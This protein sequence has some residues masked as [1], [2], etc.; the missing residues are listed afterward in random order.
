[1]VSNILDEGT[2][3]DFNPALMSVSK[4]PKTDPMV[5][6]G[7]SLQ[8]NGSSE[9]KVKKRNAS[10]SSY[11]KLPLLALD[12]LPQRLPWVTDYIRLRY[13]RSSTP[14]LPLSPGAPTTD[15][16]HA[17]NQ[18]CFHKCLELDRTN[19]NKWA[20]LLDDSMQLTSHRPSPTEQGL[21]FTNV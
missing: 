21:V 8:G 19:M 14:G 3:K 11:R 10:S 12:M 2:P 16:W 6:Q 17:K 5:W 20:D 4:L 18:Q 13:L 9:S 15:L 7:F 1:M